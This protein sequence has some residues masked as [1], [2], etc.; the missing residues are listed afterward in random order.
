VSIR[1]IVWNS[2]V[3]SPSPNARTVIDPPGR[4]LCAMP[5]IS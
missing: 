1:A 2:V 5:L 3:L 4:R